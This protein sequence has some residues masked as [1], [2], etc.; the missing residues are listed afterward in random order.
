MHPSEWNEAYTECLQVKGESGTY[1]TT[2]ATR[3]LNTFSCKLEEHDF[4]FKFN[5][6]SSG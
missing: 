3:C 1:H 2:S 6:L 5:L 4:I